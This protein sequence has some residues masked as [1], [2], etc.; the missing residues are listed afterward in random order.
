[1]YL[2]PVLPGTEPAY[3][4]VDVTRVPLGGYTVTIYQ[5]EGPGFVCAS[6]GETYDNLSTAEVVDVLE[7]VAASTFGYV[8]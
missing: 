2:D 1:M 8:S 4:R 5:A 3:V 6:A 7:A